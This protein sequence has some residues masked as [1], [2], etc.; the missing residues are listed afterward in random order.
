MESRVIALVCREQ[1]IPCATVRVIS[2]DASQDLP[3][4]F[5]QFLTPRG[6]FKWPK[7]LF[8][9]ARSPAKIGQLLQ[10]RRQLQTAAV[11]LSNVLCLVVSPESR[12][13]GPS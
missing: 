3:L 13:P 6:R 5:N 2:D 11:S 1:G 9:L 4:D 7:L 10:F 8:N 12:M